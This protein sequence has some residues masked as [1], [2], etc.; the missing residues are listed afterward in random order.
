M[1][2]LITKK[3][4]PTASPTT[5][6]LP[7]RLCARDVPLA[8]F[9]LS[10]F[11]IGKAPLLSEGRRQSTRTHC[12]PSQA[13]LGDLAGQQPAMAQNDYDYTTPLGTCGGAG[14]GTF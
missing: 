13:Q 7:A 10:L 3:A 14:Q 1:A 5:A 2:A 12:L 6:H 9:T 8:F 4:M 11:A